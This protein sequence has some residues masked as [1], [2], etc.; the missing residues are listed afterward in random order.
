MFFGLPFAYLVDT[1]PLFYP[2]NSRLW[3]YYP[4]QADV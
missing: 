3:L 1:L 4:T 2:F